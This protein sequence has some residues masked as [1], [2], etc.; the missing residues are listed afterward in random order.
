MLTYTVTYTN[1]SG[2]VI[3]NIDFADALTAPAGTS[4]LPGSINISGAREVRIFRDNIDPG[5]DFQDGAGTSGDDGVNSFSVD[6]DELDGGG[7]GGET[8]GESGGDVQILT[9]SGREVIRI[10]DDN[11]QGLSLIHI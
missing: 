11:G 9:D 10:R 8:D 2:D 6:W 5:D 4:L 1:N 7:G 3:T